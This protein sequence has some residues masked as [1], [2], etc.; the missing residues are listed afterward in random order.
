MLIKA[1]GPFWREEEVWPGG[2]GRRELLGRRGGRS[3]LEVCNFWRQQ[4]LY[5]LYHEYGPYYVGLVR[6]GNLG[7]RL[8]THRFRDR[9]SGKWDRFSWFGFTRVLVRQDANRLQELG[10]RAENL[11]GSIAGAISD[12]E[13]LLIN[14]LG[15][16]ENRHFEHFGDA[17]EWTQVQ[18]DKRD[19]TLDKL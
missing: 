5:V 12:I 3:N 11:H 16:R 19:E 8:Y 17:Y 13:A 14:A 18:A 10:T 6:D 2:R 4:G 7:N 9:Q 15:P 1:F